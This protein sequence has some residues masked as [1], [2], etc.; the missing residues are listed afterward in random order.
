MSI[1]VE[2]NQEGW[3]L[4]SDFVLITAN[5]KSML[6]FYE[7]HLW[8][9]YIKYISTAASSIQAKKIHIL[10]GFWLLLLSDLFGN[11]SH[12]GKILSLKY[13]LPHLRASGVSRCSLSEKT[14]TEN[15][16]TKEDEAIGIDNVP[17]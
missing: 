11:E 14:V 2:L 9:L 16:H 7:G 17:P 3:S 15:S 5:T 6:L 12:S 10:G 13:K 1:R 4:G 8:M